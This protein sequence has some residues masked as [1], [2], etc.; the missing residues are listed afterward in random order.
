MSR[1]FEI[2][3]DWVPLTGR[4]RGF[5][6]RTLGP[7]AA[8]TSSGT[9]PPSGNTSRGKSFKTSSAFSNPVHHTFPTNLDL[10]SQ[11]I[12]VCQH[13]GL[14]FAGVEN[15]SDCQCSSGLASGAQITPLSDCDSLCPLPPGEG[16]EFCGG[17]QRLEVYQFQPR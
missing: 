15:G 7:A 12:T 1:L 8:L 16:N 3:S 9:G 17:F 13:I 5:M 2:R 4:R 11:C 10:V 6:N 14:P